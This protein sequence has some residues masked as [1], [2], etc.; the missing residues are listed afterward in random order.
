MGPFDAWQ[1]WGRALSNEEFAQAWMAVGVAAAAPAASTVGWLRALQQDPRRATR[2]T[3]LEIAKSVLTDALSSAREREARVTWK[4]PSPTDTVDVERNVPLTGIPADAWA[5]AW[6][7][8]LAN[9]DVN[10]RLRIVEFPDAYAIAPWLRLLG[11]ARPAAQAVTLTLQSASAQLHVEWPIRVGV[12]PDDGA[13]T[14]VDACLSLWPSSRLARRVT[15]DRDNANCDLLVHRG[16]AG[17]LLTALRAQP[18]RCKANLLV[19]VGALD[20]DADELRACVNALAGEAAASGVVQFTGNSTDMAVGDMLNRFVE[21]FSHDAPVDAALSA[22]SQRLRPD[23]ALPWLTDDLAGSRLGDVARR[24]TAAA[25]ALPPGTTIDL[26]GVRRSAL[27]LRTTGWR[28]GGEVPAAT[29]LTRA[30]P[31]VIEVDV[32]HLTYDRESHGASDLTELASA[33]GRAVPPPDA[34]ARRAGRFLQQQSFIDIGGETRPADGGFIVGRPAAVRIRIGPDQGPWQSLEKAFPVEQLPPAGN[35]W[36]LTVW[37]SEPSQLCQPLHRT[38]VLPRDGPSTECEFRFTPAMARG[39]EGRITVLHRGRVL[40]TAVLRAAVVSEDATPNPDGS[41]KLADLIPVRHRLGDLE[42]RREFDLAFVVNHTVAGEPGGVALSQDRAWIADVSKSLAGIKGINAALSKVARSVDDYKDGLAGK[43]G[44]ALLVDLAKQGAWLNLYLVKGQLENPRNRPD[45]AEK[46]YIQVV[47]TRSD[48]T[49]PFEF[50]YDYEVPDNDATLC[51]HWREALAAGKCAATCQHADGKTVCPMGFWGLRKVIERH[52]V[53]PEHASDGKEFFLQSEPGRATSEL[54]LGGPALFGSS[55]RVSPA[56]RA[57]VERALASRLGAAPKTV[58]TWADWAT[59]VEQWTPHLL[60]ALPHTD[61]VG[62]NVSL[63]IGGD[64]LNTIQI[65]NRHVRPSPSARP[66]LVA[67]LGCDLA[68]TADD[69]GEH[70]VVFRARGA[71]IVI[72]TIA[73][74]FGEHAAQVATWL[75]EALIPAEGV[76]PARLGEVIRALKRRG[77]QEGLLMPLCLVAYGDADW[78]LTR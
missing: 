74:V 4:F 14:I 36:R 24:L 34:E 53:S 69:Y 49:V 25:A 72:G 15:I 52:Q 28:G 13:A 16:G 66:P 68:G 64:T 42:G 71:A 10:P 20:T 21:T 9:V 35:Q 48:A 77:L 45:I 27:R 75:T 43:A 32:V 59:T 18:V 11:E 58:A 40:Q 60:L 63:E 46:E 65:R 51:P 39:F 19:L 56:A 17:S 6:R 50:I 26:S 44:Q 30:D 38:V 47:S 62:A 67:L 57:G 33:I 70:V 31:T 61:G 5:Q 78:K 3:L 12:L 54:N 73:T 1:E 37:L 29:D 23:D 22:A 7:D 76:A 41:P 8:V 55:S 2:E